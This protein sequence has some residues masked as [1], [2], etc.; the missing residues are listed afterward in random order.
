M[1]T[2]FDNK[3]VPA[4]CWY[5]LLDFNDVTRKKFILEIEPDSEGSLSLLAYNQF[6]ILFKK[7]TEFELA[8]DWSEFE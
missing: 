7:V 5:Y 6:W 4:R 8:N 3:E 2:T 1:K